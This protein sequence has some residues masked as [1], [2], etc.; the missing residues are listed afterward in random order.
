MTSASLYVPNNHYKLAANLMGDFIPKH[1]VG[2]GHLCYKWSSILFVICL[3]IRNRSMPVSQHLLFFNMVWHAKLIPRLICTRHYS[4]FS[5]KYTSLTADIERILAMLASASVVASCFYLLS[6]P[7]VFKLTFQLPF[8]IA[9]FMQSVILWCYWT[10]ATLQ[11]ELAFL[12]KNH[13]KSV[14]MCS[15]GCIMTDNAHMLRWC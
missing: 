4:N 6:Q 15:Q 1:C 10:H 3:K 12:R 8:L 9:Y 11:L 5:A 2:A 14:W 7:S 13:V